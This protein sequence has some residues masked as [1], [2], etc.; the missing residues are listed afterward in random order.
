MSVVVGT[1]LLAI[2]ILRN[3]KDGKNSIWDR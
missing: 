3:E 2:Y 1:F